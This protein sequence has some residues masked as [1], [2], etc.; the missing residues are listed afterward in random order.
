M[1]EASGMWCRFPRLRQRLHLGSGAQY[2]IRLPAGI[3]R[4]WFFAA[5]L[6]AQGIPTAIYYP[7][8]MHQQTAYRDFPGRRM[9]ACRSARRSR[10]MS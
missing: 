5:A 8:S 10:P 7:K 9:A 2:T 3:D 6:K 4:G 1:R